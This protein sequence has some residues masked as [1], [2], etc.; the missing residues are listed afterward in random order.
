M[1][2]DLELYSRILFLDLRPW[3]NPELSE[4]KYRQDL[5]EIERIYYSVQ[6]YYELDFPRPLTNRRKFYCAI[7][8]KGAI[9]F[10]NQLKGNVEGSL[11]HDAKKYH[12]N[13][14]LTR[15]LKQKLT[16]VA[17][18]FKQR[19]YLP[20]DYTPGLRGIELGGFKA[21]ESYIFHYLKHQL[22]RLYLEVQEAYSKLMI[23]DSLSLDEVYELFFCEPAPSPSIII[24]AERIDVGHPPIDYKEPE[25]SPN[26]R[27]IR[28]DVREEKKGVLPYDVMVK[29]QDRFAW[30]EEKLFLNKYIDH[31]YK[32]TD[33]HGL[34][35]EMALV[36]NLV[37][38]SGYFSPMDYKR[39]KP[40]KPLDVRKFLD[41]RYSASLDK[42]FR[43]L[44]S[45]PQKA[46]QIREKMIWLNTLPL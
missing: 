8:E 28:G 21:D 31:N 39:R 9:K 4:M 29:K 38:D 22:V 25:L 2:A 42:Q 18:I 40:I 1:T 32:F 20:D 16:E 35:N 43:V 44:R 41:H 17:E 13:W 11:T 7:I 34:K 33:D 3:L 23:N 46:A 24:E 45:N 26:F 10:I 14:A 15:T 30:V 37:Y 12:V 6:P 36:Y 19:G 27:L 5:Q